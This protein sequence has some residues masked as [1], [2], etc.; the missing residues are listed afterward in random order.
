MIHE[1][2]SKIAVWLWQTAFIQ[3]MAQKELEG[4]NG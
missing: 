2:L 3:Q 4:T 1:L